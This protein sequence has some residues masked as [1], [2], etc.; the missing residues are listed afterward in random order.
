MGKKALILIDWQKGFLD[1]AYWGPARNNPAA[2]KN[3]ARCLAYARYHFDAVIHVCH[4]S[5]LPVSPLYPGKESHE[6]MDFAKPVE[7]EAVYGK[8]VNSAF[9]GTTLAHDLESQGIGQLAICGVSTDH[10]VST[11]TRMAANLGF[12][13]TLIGDACFTFD[14]KKPDGSFIPAQIVHDVNLASLHDEF[15]HVVTTEDFV[16]AR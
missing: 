8:S 13:I 3:A 2:E 4:N 7:A 12:D 15:A 5:S 9:I 1:A 6:F 10:C 14:R 16:G 11:S